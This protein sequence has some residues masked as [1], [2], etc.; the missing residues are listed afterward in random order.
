M[1][2]FKIVKEGEVYNAFFCIKNEKGLGGSR[3]FCL[4]FNIPWKSGKIKNIINY[5]YVKYPQ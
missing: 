2:I 4:S 3:L 1:K 5:K